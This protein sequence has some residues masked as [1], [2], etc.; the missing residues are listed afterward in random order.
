MGISGIV[1]SLDQWRTRLSQPIDALPLI[2]F[3]IGFGLLMLVSIARFWLRGWISEQYIEPGYHFSFIP[4]LVPLLGDGLYVVFGLMA[5]TAV[6]IAIGLFYRLS[7]ISFFLLFTYVELLDKAFYLNHYYLISLLT[8]LLIFLPANCKWSVDAVWF[9]SIRANIVPRWSLWLLRFQIGLVYFFAGVAKLNPD[10]LTKAMPLTI[11]LPTKA[12]LPL[13]GPLFTLPLTAYIMSWAGMLFDLTIV[14]WL[15]IPRTRPYAY[16]VVVVFHTATAVLFP[17]IGM[18][19]YIMTFCALI[20]FSGQDWRRLGGKLRVSSQEKH[21]GVP[22]QISRLGFVLL[23]VFVVI[24]TLLPL[25]HWVYPG[26]VLWN[27][28]GYRFS[29]RVML[30][31]KTGHATFTVVDKPT[32]QQ[33]VVYPSDHLTMQ[34]EKQFAF[35]PDMLVQFAHHLEEEFAAD[36]F[37]DVEIYAEAFVSLNGRRSQPFIDPSVDLTAD[38]SV[39]QLGR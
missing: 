11:W 29:W 20:F 22:H 17:T 18:F 12:S 33:W 26:N 28:Q 3:R 10:W 34:Q 8:L 31:E 39:L 9:P 25:R 30:V 13:I 2:I 14:L 32:G 37:A 19:P 6:L 1:Q 27:E 24:Q 7:A 23:I 16:V 35:Q 5:L 38:P 15:I 36:G 21:Y 4:G